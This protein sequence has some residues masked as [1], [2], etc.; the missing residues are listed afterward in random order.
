MK[1]LH[2][3][4]L[5]YDANQLYVLDQKKLP[6]QEEWILCGSP[7][8]MYDII[9]NL[10]VRGAPLIGIAAALALAQFAEKTKIIDAI[11]AAAELLKS[12]RPTAVN[13]A[14]CIDK[15]LTAL[16]ATNDYQSIVTVAEELFLEDENLC[17]RIAQHGFNIINT[18]DQILT[19]CNTGRLVTT[20]IGTA[21]GIIFYAYTQGKTL[22]VYVDETRPLL[23]GARLTTWELQREKIPYTLICDNMA[24]SLMQQQKI[25]KIIVGADR[26][27]RNGDFANKI[28]TYNLAVLAHYHQIPFYVAA[29]YTTVDHN[30]A[31][32][33]DILIEQRSAAEVRGIEMQGQKYIWSTSECKVFNPAF[34]VTPGELVTGFI[35][36]TGIFKAHELH[37]TE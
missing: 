28:G 23:Q 15:Q 25:T 30:C 7:S 35:L 8:H 14:Y 21:L 37:R 31:G 4:S 36:D 10:Q 3:A 1:N 32:S 29:P 24:A 11:I 17:E 16:H 34:D 18:D 5:R 33:S 2:S 19:H 26:I 12:A 27:A 22:H 20:G 13:L 6:Q 9:Q